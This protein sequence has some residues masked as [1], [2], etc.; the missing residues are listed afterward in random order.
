MSEP[1]RGP[2]E[3]LKFCRHCHEPKHDH[4]AAR[5]AAQEGRDGSE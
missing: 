5:P 4:D 1:A 3:E 2:A